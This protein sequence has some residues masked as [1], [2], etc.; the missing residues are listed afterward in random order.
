MVNLKLLDS[1]KDV[2]NKL[3]INYRENQ[4]R[5]YKRSCNFLES[6]NDIQINQGGMGLGKTL[7]ICKLISDHKSSFNHVFIATPISQ[8]KKEWAKELSRLDLDFAIWY[9]KYSHCIEKIKDPKFDL[10]LCNDDS[11]YNKELQ[12][13]SKQE[14]KTYTDHCVYLA[15]LVNYLNF[16]I[17]DYYKKN[18]EHCFIPINRYHLSTKN[19]IVGDF[20]GYLFPKMYSNIVKRQ[21]QNALLLIDEAHMIPERVS[22]MLSKQINLNQSIK[23]ISQ[24]IQSDYYPVHRISEL[25]K[26]IKGL[27][28]LGKILEKLIKKQE[29]K[30]DDEGR[31]ILTDFIS[32]WEEIS[33]E[34]KL[35]WTIRNFRDSLDNFNIILIRKVSPDNYGIYIK[36]ISNSN[37]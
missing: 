35:N 4:F 17:S 5:F 15:S 22:N 25:G 11:D 31:Y 32:D 34:I 23:N 24:E 3:K 29:H 37:H 12:N 10:K 2:C 20:F 9:A 14:G 7:A 28:V 36:I 19:I 26:V 27:E 30:R 1:W 33:G 16:D 8:I 21:T 18:K 6:E 13:W